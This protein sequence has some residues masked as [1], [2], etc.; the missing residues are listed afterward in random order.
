MGLLM[1]VLRK[2]EGG[3][4]L[5]DDVVGLGLKL[6]ALR[7]TQ[8]LQSSEIAKMLKIAKSTYS[9][10]ENDKS[11]P[12]YK[13][14]IELANFYSVSVDYLL[15]KSNDQQLYV[16]GNATDEVIKVEKVKE[17]NIF[18]KRLR[19]LRTEKCITQAELGV[20]LNRAD[21]NISKYEV[22]RIEPNIETL[23]AIAEYFQVSSDY[24]IGISNTQNHIESQDQSI[25]SLGTW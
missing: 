13:I 17:K 9:G 11:K 19:I 21:G 5:R 14:L 20:V 10:Y 18:G 2:M 4:S 15:G 3:I 6:K 22:G 25:L 12:N 24:L 23:Q 16:P 1:K 8:N 7:R